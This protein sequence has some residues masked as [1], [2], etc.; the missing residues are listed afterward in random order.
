MVPGTMFFPN[1]ENAWKKHGP[2]DHVFSFFP[3]LIFLFFFLSRLIFLFFFLS[4]RVFCFFQS[5][6]P[7]PT[8]GGGVASYVSE[9]W[10]FVLCFQS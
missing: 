7:S 1:L 2:W 3:R 10:R 6:S 8:V 5:Q 4:R 9:I